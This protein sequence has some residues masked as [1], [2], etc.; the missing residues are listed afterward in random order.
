MFQCYMPIKLG[1]KEV[2]SQHSN[3]YSTEGSI[4]YDYAR[5][6]KIK[7]YRIERKKIKLSLFSGT[8]SVYIEKK[9]YKTS[10]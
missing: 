2:C 3:K 5:R 4:N 8:R 9:N 6:E 7:A 10:T 1:R